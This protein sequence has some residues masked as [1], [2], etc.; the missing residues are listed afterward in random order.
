MLA[1]TGPPEHMLTQAFRG[2][3]WHKIRGLF[4]T[5][6]IG[7]WPLWDQVGTVAADH[8]SYGSH[9]V[10][11]LVAARVNGPDQVHQA[12]P[13]DGDKSNV[14]ILT[15]GLAAR[16]SGAEGT[17]FCW[18]KVESAAVYLD[19]LGHGTAI[20]NVDV[21][22]YARLLLFA[23]TWYFEHMAGGVYVSRTFITALTSWCLVAGT[24][25][26]SNDRIRVYLNG[27]KQGADL[28][29]LGNWAGVP[30]GLLIGALNTTPDW[31]WLGWLAHVG[32]LNREA[33]AAELLQVCVI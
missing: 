10:G 15:A 6:L 12:A 31:C 20:S 22:N 25:S 13:F 8:S 28:G 24:W 26:K 5:S 30:A 9:G 3:Y 23:G 1:G 29:G 11:N 19:G 16:F 33:S 32:L 18:T 2:Q 14:N 27:V 17:W 4:G 7:Y 21:N